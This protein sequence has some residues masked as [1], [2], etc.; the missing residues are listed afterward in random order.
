[1]CGREMNSA[2]WQWAAWWQVTQTEHRL[3]SSFITCLS[4]HFLLYNQ[5]QSSSS[6]ACWDWSL[7]APAPTP[8]PTATASS[9]LS[10]SSSSLSLPSLS[11]CSGESLDVVVDLALFTVA[12][13]QWN[14]S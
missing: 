9:F 3:R 8:G 5:E 4:S 6:L 12:D 2:M 14:R 1:M 11:S 13:I 10:S 7:P